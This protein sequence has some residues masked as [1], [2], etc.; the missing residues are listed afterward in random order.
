MKKNQ[1]GDIPEFASYLKVKPS[2]LF[3]YDKFQCGH[4]GYGSIVKERNQFKI[5]LRPL[6]TS[7]KD[8]RQNLTCVSFAA[9][10]A[11]EYIVYAL[12]DDPFRDVEPDLSESH[13]T[14]AIEKLHGDCVGGLSIVE[15]AYYLRYNGCVEETSWPYNEHEICSANPP[16]LALARRYLTDV[17]TDTS[18]GPAFIH[19]E[20]DEVIARIKLQIRGITKSFRTSNI[21]EMCCTHLSQY[22]RPVVVDVPVFWSKDDFSAGWE[23]GVIEMPTP[24]QLKSWLTQTS[25]DVSGSSGWHAICLTGYNEGRRRFEFKNSWGKNWGFSGYGTI[26]FEYLDS[27]SRDCW[28]IGAT[29][30]TMVGPPNF[31]V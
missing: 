26:P 17:I 21:V 5:S 15:L 10:G 20:H 6:M 29:Y 9:I 12:A 30:S 25:K 23:I 13:I 4:D 8:Q 11:F 31:G 19:R 27:Y 14:H 18:I 16:N 1:I 2:T 7:V 28:R 3:M 22:R 24:N